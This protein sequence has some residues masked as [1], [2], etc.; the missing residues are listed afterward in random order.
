MPFASPT[1]WHRGEVRL[2]ASVG[3]AER[4]EAAGPRAIRDAMPEQHQAFYAQLPFVVTATVDP[5]GR[6]W[7]SLL[8]GRPGFLKPEGPHRLAVAATFAP[9]DPAAAG[10]S[11]GQ[12]IGLLGIE[13]HSRRRN[14]L[15][16]RIVEGEDQGF[17]VAVEQAFGNCPKYIRP[18]RVST[19]VAGA[20]SSE[21]LSAL[22]AEAE[23]MVGLADT[24][25][26]ASFADTPSGGRQIDASHRG[27]PAGFVRLE[28]DGS[29]T[30]PDFS[31]NRFFNTLGNILESGRAGLLFIDFDSGDLL[32]MTGAAE[33]VV[34]GAEI[35]TF[36]DAERL[37]RLRPEAVVRRRGALSLRWDLAERAERS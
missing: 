26:V 23:A 25:F 18:R 7:A 33:V 4:L 36:P 15:N 6:P 17:A 37:W 31:G 3:V 9:Q 5:K 35:Q 2:Q 8:T 10:A 13:L 11:P 34:E 27:G 16:G 12:P 19:V 29:L 30:I 24:L 32:Q 28:R 21:R 14:R 1:P 20:A 22:D